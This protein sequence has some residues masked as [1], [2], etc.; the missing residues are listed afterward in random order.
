MWLR[1]DE[2]E[3]LAENLFNSIKDDSDALALVVDR[4]SDEMPVRI[5]MSFEKA[6]MEDVDLVRIIRKFVNGSIVSRFRP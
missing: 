4:C 5:M 2:I 3:I 6:L 1:D